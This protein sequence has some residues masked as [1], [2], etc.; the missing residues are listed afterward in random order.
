MVEKREFLAFPGD[1]WRFCRLDTVQS[2]LVRS[3]GSTRWHAGLCMQFGEG[4]D[5]KGVQDASM[6]MNG[7]ASVG[8]HW[9]LEGKHPGV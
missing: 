1:G 8:S 2:F 7:K 6:G 3:N 4:G 9:P 5:G